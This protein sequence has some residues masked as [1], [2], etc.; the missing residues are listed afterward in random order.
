MV[1]GVQAGG[2][3]E[4]AGNM[5]STQGKSGSRDTDGRFVSI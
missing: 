5:S 3:R 1:L 4:V 2:A